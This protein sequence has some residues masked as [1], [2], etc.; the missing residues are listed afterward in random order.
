MCAACIDR[1][2]LG[3]PFLLYEPD[4]FPNSMTMQDDVVGTLSNITRYR[5]HGGAIRVNIS[6]VIV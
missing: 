4:M 1:A 5:L 2:L 3:F 6:L